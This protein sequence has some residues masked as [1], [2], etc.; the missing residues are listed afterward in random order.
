MAVTQKSTITDN[1]TGAV[2]GLS[3]TINNYTF[4]ELW[5][6][7]Y[8]ASQ[9]DELCS[10]LDRTQD[11]CIGLKE[12]L[13]DETGKL[14]VTLT[15]TFNGP[16]FDY[17][18][19]RYDKGTMQYDNTDG[20]FCRVIW[21]Y[22][23]GTMNLPTTKGNSTAKV[24]T[25]LDMSKISL[26]MNDYGEAAG[27]AAPFD[28][29]T[30]WESIKPISWTMQYNG[31][32]MSES[33]RIY[34]YLMFKIA[35]RGYINRLFYRVNLTDYLFG[36]NQTYRD[37]VVWS[38]VYSGNK[39]VYN[40]IYTS[41]MIRTYETDNIVYKALAL[42]VL[43]ADTSISKMPHTYNMFRSG[44]NPYQSYNT[45][46]DGIGAYINFSNAGA[47]GITYGAF[48]HD[49]FKD[50]CSRIG[51]NFET[52]KKYKVIIKDGAV[53]GYTDNLS[54]ESEIDS[55]TGTTKHDVPD[56]PPAPTPTGDDVDD[57]IL[58]YEGYENGFIK[59]YVVTSGNLQ[60][61]SEKIAEDTEHLNA[62][63]N[64]VSLKSYVIPTNQ[65]IAAAVSDRITISGIDTTVDAPRI[66]VTKS[67]YEIGSTVV[68]GKYG[69]ASDPHFLDFA[70][71]TQIE[72]YI[73]FCGVV[74]LPDW[75]MY[76]TIHVILISDIIAGSC[77][78][79]VKCNGDIVAERVGVLGIDAPFTSQANALKNSAMLQTVLNGANIG[80]QTLVSGVSG[81][82]AGIAKNTLQ[83]LAN[84]QQSI[85]AGNNNYTVTVGTAPD[86]IEYAMPASCYI[87]V[88][89]PV[90]EE[91]ENYLHTAGKPLMKKKTLSEMSGFTVCSN[92]DTDGIRS[93]T[94]SERDKIKSLLE[95]GI[96]I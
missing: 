13:N 1:N 54:A 53:I 24:I 93:A 14:P 15:R 9:F 42:N 94:A 25:S 2:I 72:V 77:K 87:K 86:R 37:P 34:P 58:G 32:N 18:G 38:N 61:I 76:K 50:L 48:T 19:V 75:V 35:D 84:I 88:Y 23:T 60:T 90:K 7:A 96:I 41:N 33:A 11:T 43:N 63:N 67:D 26:K 5:D 57:M 71:Y 55:Y 3:D 74:Q 70:P 39:E 81:N 30:T 69:T 4:D 36:V 56:K 79:I 22:S 83:G 82:Y 95:T 89:S 45:D 27:T 6:Y 59:H 20:I 31:I 51:A 8:V 91:P 49:K 80:M 66:T 16:A 21:T 28:D 52:D 47:G 17:A 12:Y 73:P 65:F 29:I 85:L 46:I 62:I 78:G 44:W 64:I 68:R 40:Q 92:V 10:L